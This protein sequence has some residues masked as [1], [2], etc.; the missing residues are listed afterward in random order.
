MTCVTLG[1]SGAGFD[2]AA[3]STQPI[4]NSI[5]WQVVPRSGETCAER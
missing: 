5:K 2:A 1:D 3:A 4:L